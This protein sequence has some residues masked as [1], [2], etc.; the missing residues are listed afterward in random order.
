[1][2][3][4]GMVKFMIRCHVYLVIVQCVNIYICG[5]AERFDVASDSIEIRDFTDI[6]VRSRAPRDV[7][8]WWII[9]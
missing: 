9:E 3:L 5:F 8:I 7:C 1:M 6:A 4:N 2:V